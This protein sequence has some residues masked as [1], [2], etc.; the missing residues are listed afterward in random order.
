METRRYF[1]SIA[2]IIM[3]YQQVHEE[4][5]RWNQLTGLHGKVAGYSQS[6]AKILPVV[7]GTKWTCVGD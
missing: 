3:K 7:E 6:W 1:V 4:R 2:R 5:E